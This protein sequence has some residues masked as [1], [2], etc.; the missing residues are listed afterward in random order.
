M[1]IPKAGKIR[2]MCHSGLRRRDKGLELLLKERRY[3]GKIK[4][5]CFVDKYFLGPLETMGHRGL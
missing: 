3:H 1:E 4:N 2:C 5:K